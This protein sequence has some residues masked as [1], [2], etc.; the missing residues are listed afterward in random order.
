MAYFHVYLGP[1]W[2]HAGTNRLCP[3]NVVDQ[4]W[5]YA[6]KAFW[7]NYQN[8]FY[9]YFVHDMRFVIIKDKWYFLINMDSKATRYTS[10][11]TVYPSGKN[12]IMFSV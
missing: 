12:L 2:D 8:I 3:V 4:W 7:D 11:M 10:G 1:Y 6:R 9:D 5:F